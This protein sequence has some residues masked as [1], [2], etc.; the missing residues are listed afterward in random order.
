MN[1]R[2][3]PPLLTLALAVGL[4]GCFLLPKPAHHWAKVT[5]VPLDKSAAV[6]PATHE[7]QLYSRAVEAIEQR[8]YGLALDILQTARDARPDDA[9]VLTAMGVVY[10]KLGRFDLSGRYYDLADKADPGSKIVAIDR[11]YSTFLQQAVRSERPIQAVVVAEGPAVTRQSS[12]I[13]LAAAPTPAIMLG[14]PVRV[15][16][17]TGR[18]D[19]VASVESRLAGKGWT[20]AQAGPEIGVLPISKVEYPPTDSRVAA[21]L[22]RTLAFPVKLESCA[23][24]TQV[25]LVVGASALASTSYGMQLRRGGARG[26]N[27]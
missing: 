16:N 8:D 17:A 9:R 14:G 22:A 15:H 18:S 2:H 21:G 6:S 25:V 5:P 7:D 4:S 10:D 11:R 13:M 1:R 24:C 20:L 23:S 19:G 12:A 26:R 3:R 27:D